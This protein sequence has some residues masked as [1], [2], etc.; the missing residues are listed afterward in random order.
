MSCQ[1]AHRSS[2]P[3]LNPQLWA[4][5]QCSSA[6]KSPSEAQFGK[7]IYHYNP[8]SCKNIVSILLRERNSDRRVASLELPGCMHAIFRCLV[9]IWKKEAISHLLCRCQ[10]V[11]HFHTQL[12]I[13]T[14]L[15]GI[16]HL[17]LFLL[18]PCKKMRG[19][20]CRYIPECQILSNDAVSRPF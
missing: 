7:R 4:K 17:F 2:E 1:A 19:P 18:F 12:T 14:F 6:L 10:T 16:G 5:L 20:S 9:V 11:T 3:L 8:R 13:S 15:H